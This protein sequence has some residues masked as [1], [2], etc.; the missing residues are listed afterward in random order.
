LIVSFVKLGLGV[1]KTRPVSLPVGLGLYPDV[2]EMQI[3]PAD[4][5]LLEKA[6]LSKKVLAPPNGV[7]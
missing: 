2:K 3:S 1:S 4:F 6:L 7:A 5:P